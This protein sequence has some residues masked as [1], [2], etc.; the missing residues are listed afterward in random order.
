MFLAVM[1]HEIR[2]P[3]NAVLAAMELLWHTRLNDQQRHFAHL[4]N[5]GANMLVRL[6]DDVLHRPDSGAKAL[7]LTRGD[8]CHRAGAWRSGLASPACGEKHLSLNV[9]VQT[10]AVVVA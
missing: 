6:L 2:S 7:R 5:S 9:S 1:G 3:M 10:P 8:G 4:A